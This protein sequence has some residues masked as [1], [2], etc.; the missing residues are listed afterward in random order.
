MRILLI[1]RHGQVG[2]ELERRLADLGEVIATDRSSLDLADPDAIVRGVRSARPEVIVNAA[3]YT[4]VDRAESEPEVAGRINAAAPAVLAEEARRGHALLLHYSTDYVFDGAK[5]QPYTEEDATN[6]LNVYGASKLQG[7]RA[8]AASACRHLILRTSWVYAARGKN[9]LLSILRAARE[10]RGL[11]VV[12]DQ[13]GAP[14]SAPA[15]AEATV[16]LLRTGK[17]EGLYHMSAGGKTTWHGFAEAILE[18]A[19]LAVA[20]QRISSGQY[21]AP[22]RRP[23]NS[24]LENARMHRDFAFALGDW[25]G[26]LASV[27]REFARSPEAYG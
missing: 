25:R 3:A 6:P 5:P 27:M 2:W 19:G 23:R 22:A 18:E 13:V 15:I 21:G 26:E 7:E 14:T 10:K 24:L 4:A 17:A 1:G 12:D 9:F 20:V 11:R 16:R 8:I